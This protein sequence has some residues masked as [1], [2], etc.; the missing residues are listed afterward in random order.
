[1]GGAKVG[2]L[3]LQGAARRHA[4]ALEALGATAVALGRPEHLAGLDAVVLPG[5]ESTTIA[6]LLAGTG[7]AEPLRR[8]LAEGDLGVLGTCAGMI[9]LAREV[10]DGRPDQVGLGTMDLTVRRNAFG[11]Q[12][13]SFEAEVAVAGLAGGPFPATFIRAPVVTRVGPGVEVLATV[14]GQPVLCRQD[15]R[16]ACA[17]HPELSADLRLHEAFLASI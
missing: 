12:P 13:A 17:F 9:L 7:L 3:G 5:G 4:E 6:R 1:V 10:L 15:R 14:D 16:W 8:A 2:V 11:P